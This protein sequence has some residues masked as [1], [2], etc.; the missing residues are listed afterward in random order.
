MRGDESVSAS[1][2]AEEKPTDEPVDSRKKQKTESFFG[3]ALK[4][5]LGV[6]SAEGEKT[7]KTSPDSE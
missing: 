6:K 4:A 3:R 2:D 5:S 1:A 7:Q